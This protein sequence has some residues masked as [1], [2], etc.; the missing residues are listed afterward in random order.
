[1]TSCDHIEN[2]SLYAMG[3]LEDG[4]LTSFEHHLAV[5]DSCAV[6]VRESGDLL[7]APLAAI[8]IAPPPASLRERVLKH[9]LLPH[10]VVALVRG[11]QIPWQNTPFEGISTARL[12]ENPVTGEI[13]S[14]VKMMPGARY[15]S[16]HHKGLEHCY[17]IEGDLVFEDHTLRTGDYA[18]GCP[19]GDHSSSTTVNGCLLFIVHN[20][21]DVIY[22]Q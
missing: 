8:D 4:E 19:D 1:M 5:C 10:G 12:F 13:T 6:E 18:A 22:A 2:A 3:L 15:P 14:L 20:L 17:V 21:Q 11:N 16:H 9:A 7:A